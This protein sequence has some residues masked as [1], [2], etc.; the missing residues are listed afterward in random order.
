M[1]F[2]E[3]VETQ[4]LSLS[5]CGRRLPFDRLREPARLLRLPLKGE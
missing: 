2:V 1:T 3:F 4:S 5:K